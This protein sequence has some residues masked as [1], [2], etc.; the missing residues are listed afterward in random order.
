MPPE[1][2]RDNVFLIYFLQYYLFNCDIM[3]YWAKANYEQWTFR[4]MISESI[5]KMGY[6]EGVFGAF[7]NFIN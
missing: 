6:V 1:Q 5:L 2:L 3:K 7:R 4:W